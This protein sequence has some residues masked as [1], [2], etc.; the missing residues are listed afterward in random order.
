MALYSYIVMALFAGYDAFS[1]YK[2]TAGILLATSHATIIN[3]L[4]G[5]QRSKASSYG[6]H[7]PSP[8]ACLLRGYGRAG[9]QNDRLGESFPTGAQHAPM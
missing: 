5:K 1:N 6:L 9:T 7:R 8:T 4:S 3:R 2:S